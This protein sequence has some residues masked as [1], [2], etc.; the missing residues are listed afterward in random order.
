MTKKKTGNAANPTVETQLK[1]MTQELKEIRE[2]RD[3][4]FK[5]TALLKRQLKEAN[6]VIGTDLKS[7]LMM[8]IKQK[9]QYN[10]VDL[11]GMTIEQLQ[12]VDAT[13]SMSKEPSGTHKNIR[14][15]MASVERSGR[16][17]IG[18]T[19]AKTPKEIAEME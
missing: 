19:Y 14:A 6:D 3:G 5:E 16:L 2:Q 17:T 9:S 12:A 13:L 10:D 15:G 8:R 4:L 11:D 1:D 7:D 18:S